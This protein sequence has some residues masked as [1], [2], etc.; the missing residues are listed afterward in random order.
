L[1]F[2]AGFPDFHAFT[3]LPGSPNDYGLRFHKPRLVSLSSWALLS[4]VTSFRQ[5]H[6]LRSFPP[7]VR[8]FLQLRVAPRLPVVSL[9]VFFFPFEAFSCHALGSLPALAS[10]TRAHSFVRRLRCAT[11]RTVVPRSRV[12]SSS[13]R[14]LKKTSS[15]DSRPLRTGPHRLSTATPSLLAL[16]AERARRPDLQS[17]EVRG[18]RRFSEETACS[19]GVCCLL[20]SLVTLACSLIRASP[21]EDS[22]SILGS[23]LRS[24]ACPLD[25]R[26]PLLTGHVAVVSA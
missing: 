13:A 26:P 8:P 16:V 12:R 9:L 14:V 19:P 5:L 11:S 21:R 10:W 4:G 6:L 15:T 3:Q 24:P 17:F 7:P 2:V 22:P 25:L 18:K 23:R 20:T 1:P